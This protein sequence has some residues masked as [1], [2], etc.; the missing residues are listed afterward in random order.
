MSASGWRGL[1]A[2][3]LRTAPLWALAAAWTA[4]ANAG[5]LPASFCALERSPALSW[6]RLAQGD[7]CARDEDGN[8]L[9][10]EIETALASCFVPEV[11][12][13]SRE[14]AL[15][16]DE[17]QVLFSAYALGA[18]LIRLHFAFLFAR[19]GGYVLGT[20]FP[21]MTDDHDGD[22]ESVAVDVA[23]IDRDGGGFGA[24]VSM[25]TG[26]PRD[27]SGEVAEAPAMA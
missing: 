26:H 10:D 23:F 13:D 18:R 15:R 2:R 3:V 6:L 22:V 19:D 7:D 12:F 20:E 1:R 27:G 24:A 4:R 25:Q 16:V 11:R 9:D 17:P 8:G 21:C 5:D 14:N